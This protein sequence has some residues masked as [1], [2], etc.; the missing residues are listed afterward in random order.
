MYRPRVLAA[1]LLVCFAAVSS[2]C[3]PSGTRVRGTVDAPS[4]AESSATP[5]PQSSV[6]TEPAAPV[7]FAIIGDCG[8]AGRSEAAVAALVASWH[9]KFIVT[10]GDNYYSQA[11]ATG[12]GT[13]Q[14][15]VSVGAYF[16]DWLKDISTTGK[17]CPVG[18]AP[19]NAFFP[20]MG[21]HDY[22]SARP[23]PATYLTYFTLPG[24]GFTS[25]SGNERYYDFVQGPVHFFILNSN[26]QE[27]DGK[28]SD[29]VQAQWLR[30]ALA[31]STAPWNVVV[32]HHPP[33]TSSNH[34][35]SDPAMQWPFAAWGADVVVA[36][37][38]HDYERI[39]RDGIIFFVNG[40]GGEGTV[41]GFA[42]PVQG[43]T[44]RFADD[45]GAQRVTATTTT[46]DFEFVT[47][48]GKAIDAVHLSANN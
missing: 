23:G 6:T 46:L 29:S 22:T 14:Y 36:G 35:P 42:P 9:P 8:A 4:A 44:M 47:T 26:R 20:T 31:A 3:V 43:S 33:Y 17:K 27:P 48:D 2:G 34:H 12:T 15:D 45:F 13:G 18:R 10:T 30:G 28:S 25:S 41:D 37:H 24:T 21:N 39:M 7:V 5:V 19:V 38:N 16:G 32:L 1:V 40:L 11:D